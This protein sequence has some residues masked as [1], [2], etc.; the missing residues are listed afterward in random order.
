MKLSNNLSVKEVTKSN[1]AKRCGIS[2]EPTIEHLENLKAIALNIFQ[3]ARNYFKKPIFVSS[4]YRSEALN[5]KIGGSKKSQH[6]KGQ[7]LDLD[8]HIFGGLT[9]QQLFKFI[10]DHTDFDQLIWEFGTDEEP[11]WVH[12]SYTLDRIN[13][14]EKLKAYKANN[15]T[16][17]KHI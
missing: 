9:N 6:S 1:T 13:R 8:A 17:Y 5:E 14:G 7:A 11:D 4:G 10:S 3:P 2:N 15:V 16:K 12:V